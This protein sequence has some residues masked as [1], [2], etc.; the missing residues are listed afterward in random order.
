MVALARDATLTHAKL[1]PALD[2]LHRGSRLVVSNPDLTHSRPNGLPVMEAGA[3]LQL[4]RACVP[5]L[6]YTVV[7]KP[8]RTMF[9]VALDR[10][11]CSAADRVMI[12]D[13][14][15][16][17]GVGSTNAGITPILVG[18]ATAAPRSRRSSGSPPNERHLAAPDPAGR[19]GS[20]REVVGRRQLHGIAAEPHPPSPTP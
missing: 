2:A 12:G 9:D 3:I 15:Y 8:S 11:G 14:P 19:R 7:G 4:F 5:D 10:F 17:D 6:E 18:A 20:P 13:N 16:T 1:A